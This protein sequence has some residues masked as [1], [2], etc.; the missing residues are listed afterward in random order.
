MSSGENLFVIES[1]RNRF[2]IGWIQLVFVYN[3]QLSG[4]SKKDL[5]RQVNPQANIISI[6][7][8]F[9]NRSILRSVS[10]RLFFAFFHIA[11]VLCRA[12]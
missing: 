8:R 11:S 10:I 3:I 6:N 9:L 2:D 5:R 1:P 7:H 4:V 12:T